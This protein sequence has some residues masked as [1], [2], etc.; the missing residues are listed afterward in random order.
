MV[1]LEDQRLAFWVMSMKPPEPSRR[2][3]TGNIDVPVHPL[4]KG[5]EARRARHHHRI[6]LIGLIEDGAD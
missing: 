1:P 2:S 6:E 5:E 4:R 3:R